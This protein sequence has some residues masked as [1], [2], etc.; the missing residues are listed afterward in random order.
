MGSS[1]ILA[2]YMGQ[3]HPLFTLDKQNS[4]LRLRYIH[5]KSVQLGGLVLLPKFRGGADKLGRQI[6]ASRFLYMLE[7][8]QIWP[9]EVEVSLTAPLKDNDRTSEFW[10]AVG[11]RVFSLNYLK[12]SE[13]YREN[14][15]RFLSRIPQNM[16]VDLKSLPKGA[17][18]AM[19][20]PHSETLSLYHGLL[21]LGFKK[22]PYRHFLDG[23]VFLK[24]KRKNIPFIAQGK[25]V[26]LK[27]GKPNHSRTWL[28]GQQI[29]GKFIGGVIEGELK[30]DRSFFPKQPVPDDM[31][32]AAS[33]FVTPLNP[34]EKSAVFDR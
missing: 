25:K 33:L 32:P 22:T 11:K 14:F 3:K 6:G 27:Q 28:W 9:E 20:T 13:L 5:N 4:F 23:G 18:Q 10:D 34:L 2:C 16:T 29:E 1:Q 26:L 21:K 15:P 30:D 31:R 24:I 7:D 17:R 8:P 12:A 19:E